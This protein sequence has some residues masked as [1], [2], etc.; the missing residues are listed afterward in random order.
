VQRLQRRKQN[1]IQ[2][3][4]KAAASPSVFGALLQ[5]LRPKNLVQLN[6]GLRFLF[7]ELREATHLYRDGAKG[8][9]DGAVRALNSVSA[10]LMLFR[11]VDSKGL[12]APLAG[13]ANALMALDNNMVEPMLRPISRRGRSPA[14][15]ARQSMK[16]LAAYVVRQLQSRGTNRMAAYRSVAVQLAKSGVRPDR[17]S[18]KVTSRTVREWCDAISA[19]IS[20]SGKA[21]Q[22][23]DIA[24]Q[25]DDS[26]VSPKQ[27]L[28]KLAHVARQTRAHDTA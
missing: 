12:Q 5:P 20:R 22:T 1:R 15:D 28:K 21:A 16:G 10:F 27:L 25:G 11:A 19:D 2:S 23:F 9:R 18:G 17:G 14:S 7:N 3:A 6:E 24:I 8:G 26:K 13:L 4:K